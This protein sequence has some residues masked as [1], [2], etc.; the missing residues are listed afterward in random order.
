MRFPG[1]LR[2]SIEGAL[3]ILQTR[4]GGMKAGFSR[5][6][7][8][9]AGNIAI[10]ASL[11]LPALMGAVGLASDYA[12]F[13]S[14]QSE[15]QGAADSAALAAAKEF[16]L[17][18]ATDMTIGAAAKSFAAATTKNTISTSVEID[19]ANE[20]VT[21]EVREEWT[22]FFAHFL[23]ADITPV[24]VRATAQLAGRANTCVLALAEDEEKSIEL[25]KNA[26]L[27]ATGC[28]VYANSEDD[29]SIKVKTGATIH[30]DLTCTVGGIDD[31]GGTIT[32]AALTDCPVM[33]DPLS[34]RAA[35]AVGACDFTNMV[36][37]TGAVTLSPGTYCG[38]LNIA[39]A[40]TVTFTEGVYVMKG[41]ALLISGNANVTGD[42]AGFYLT[43]NNAV[44]NINGNAS[45]N[46][47]GPRTGELAGILFFEDRAAPKER[48]HRI[49]ATN[50]HTLTGTIY[51]PRGELRIDP[52]SK[53]AENSA[54]TAIISQ[55]L[56]LSD[57]PELV[58][59]SDYGA[60]DVPVPSGIRS[61]AQIVLSD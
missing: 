30:A 13:I 40:A 33:D 14:K 3:G 20:S 5:Y 4:T 15:L 17:A 28:G 11:A 7:R 25:T 2:G 49:S 58:L 55:T 48:T 53:V 52:K 21:V 36:V 41:G 9:S 19:S 38:G 26:K 47:K 8:A 51:L 37:N 60:T 1:K 56:R 39:G 61:S 23:G 12:Q 50:A 18:S 22:P 54:Y 43:G 45:V 57:G 42:Y 59:N 31:G 35:P 10:S 32:P 46:M 34:S 24:I 16:T 27:K 29:E 6:L 44:I